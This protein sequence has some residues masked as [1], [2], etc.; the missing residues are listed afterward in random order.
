MTPASPSTPELARSPGASVSSEG[1]RPEAPG[2]GAPIPPGIAGSPE[3]AY[4]G[5]PQD[6]ATVARGVAMMALSQLLTVP[7]SMVVSAVL[8]RRLG[9]LD[10]G[11]LYLAQTAVGMGFLFAD[12]GQTAALAGEVA[13]DRSRAG[14]LL[15]T[16]LVLKLGLGALAALGLLGLG[17]AQG[18]SATARNAVAVLSVASLVGMLQASLTAVLRG[19]E[20]SEQ[21][22]AVGLLSNLAGSVLVVA[23]ALAGLGLSGVL[24]ACVAGAVAPIVPT[25][26]LFRRLGV[27]RPS[28]RRA[29]VA[30]LLGQGSAFLFFNL[31]LALQPYI[32]AAFLARLAPG[33]AM[34]WH[35]AT[36]RIVGVLLF[37]ATSLSFALYATLARLNREAPERALSLMRG[38][39]RLMVLIGV[40]AALGSVLFAGPVVHLIYGTGR[41][42]GAVLNLQVLSLWLLLVY[43]SILLGTYLLTANRIVTWSFVQAICLV[44][45]VLADPPL[46]RFF[47]QRL[48][49]GAVGISVSAL[50][51][52]MLMFVIGAALV[53]REMLR[54]GLA[55]ATI[56]GLIAGG[57]MA[58][59]ALALGRAPVPIAMASSLAV[60]LA[61]LLALGALK[62]QDV[63]GLVEMLR[64][65]A[66]SR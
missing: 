8:A 13:R 1:A 49:N 64:A 21:V 30:T 58:A 5:A 37:P 14:S 55:K 34:G 20:R 41:F 62:G 57:A 63:R 27:G 65:R 43:F 22:S 48:G 2:S 23:C 60:Y 50:I 4:A 29:E 52:E 38:A 9:P 61:V 39:L 17:A 40:P 25:V 45:S 35:A 12:W 36:R 42:E 46:I 15:G 44:V 59:V 66:R 51:S 19:Y 26:L 28:P 54:G 7:L 10:F 56:H 47:D 53:P 24:W 6:T 32:D 3:A 33:E 31:V 18:Y 16:S 11:A